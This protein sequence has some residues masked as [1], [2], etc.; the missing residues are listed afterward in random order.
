MH[1][2]TT[3]FEHLEDR[4]LM[5]AASL[6]TSFDGDGKKTLSL[7]ASDNVHAMCVQPDGKTIIVE[8]TPDNAWLVARFNKDGSYDSNFGNAGLRR[9]DFGD[10]PTAGGVALQSDG[11]IVIVGSAKTILNNS[12][13]VAARLTANGNLDTS[14]GFN[15]GGG[16]GYGKTYAQ[17]DTPTYYGSLKGF[18]TACGVNIRGDNSILIGGTSHVHANNFDDNRFFVLKLDKTGKVIKSFGGNNTGVAS[19]DFDGNTINAGGDQAHAMAVQWDGKILLAGQ[20]DG[21]MAVFRFNAD[22][23]RDWGFGASGG[24]RTGYQA[25]EKWSIANGVGLTQDGKV[26]LGGDSF[27]STSGGHRW[28]LARLNS[29][30]TFDDSFDYDGLKFMD[31]NNGVDKIEGI[32]VQDDG[33]IVAG[34]EGAF[35][36]GSQFAL[37]RFDTKGKLDPSFGGFGGF[38]ATGF[39]GANIV[40]VTAMCKTPDGRIMLAGDRWNSGGGTDIAMAKFIGHAPTFRIYAMQSGKEGSKNAA[41]MI[42]RDGDAWDGTYDL[43]LVFSGTAINGQDYTVPF[44]GKLHWFA[45]QTTRIIE[46]PVIDDAKKEGYESIRVDLKSDITY[47]VDGNF[48]WTQI[49][50]YDND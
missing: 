8:D 31:V 25:G 11:K 44:T 35:G 3:T 23:S 38:T 17:I 49:G 1:R 18:A 41:F 30:G 48:S 45:G 33:K 22:G 13:A 46:L 36:E 32:V 9:I 20:S 4:R 5:S 29:N 40:D 27:S 47:D 24:A 12:Y 43:N 15:M 28:A 7:Y 39:G 2:N 16:P 37:A 19:Y 14:F 26:V 34:G 50:I 6:D 10:D 42:K 21:H